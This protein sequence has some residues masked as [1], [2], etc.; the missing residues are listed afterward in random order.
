MTET[1]A[2]I[3]RCWRL[4]VDPDAPPPGPR[5]PRLEVTLERR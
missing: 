3:A 4:H 1:L 2:G 5:A